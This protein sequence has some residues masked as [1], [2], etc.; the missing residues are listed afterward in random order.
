MNAVGNFDLIG[1]SFS[2]SSIVSTS[3]STFTKT[4]S[5]IIYSGATNHIVSSISN[6]TLITSLN[7]T[8]VKLPNGLC[9]L[10]THVSVVKILDFLIL[11]IVLYIPSFSFN[12]IS[13]KWIIKNS[14]FC[15]VLHTQICF[16]QDLQAWKTFKV[17][18]QVASLYLLQDNFQ[19]F[20]MNSSTSTRFFF[21]YLIFSILG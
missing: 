17:A 11:H 2:L 12:L 7:N 9:V 14:S 10:V 18:K 19:A 8:S 5:W 1:S 13:V 4:N 15:L 6:S 3:N 20:A 16:I 21:L